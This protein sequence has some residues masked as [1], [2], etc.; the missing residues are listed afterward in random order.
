VQW[1]PLLRKFAN[2]LG[3]FNAKGGA[4]CETNEFVLSRVHTVVGALLLVAAVLAAVVAS[5]PSAAAAQSWT[6]ASPDGSISITV[7]LDS[8]LTY[9]VQ[10]QTGSGSIPV[11]AD[12]KLGLQRTD[13]LF[14]TGLT[15][16]NASP[17]VT[18]DEAYVRPHGKTSPLRNHGVQQVLEFANPQGHRLELVMRA[19]NDGVAFR[20]R[21]PE[22]DSRTFIITEELTTFNLAAEGRALLQQ[23]A[24]ESFHHL[25]TIASPHPED[26][27]GYAVPGLFESGPNWV[28][29]AES[30][31]DHSYF[32]GQLKK[33]AGLLEYGIQVPDSHYGLRDPSWT[34]P[35]EMPWR[36]IIIGSEVGDVIESNLVSH[37]AAPSR[38]AD[39][40]WIVPGRV[41]W[42]WWA[43]PSQ[44]GVWVGDA[45]GLRAYIDFAA[46]MG[47]EYS[48][49]DADWD[50]E[51]S[52]AEMRALIDYADA[53]GVGVF[54][55]YNSAGPHNDAE[56]SPR[57]KLWENTIR[58]AEFA[59]L[60]AWG[61]KGIKVDFF[62]SDKQEMIQVYLG[63]LED[64][65]AQEILVVFHASTP[66]RGWFRTWPNMLST[67]AVRGGEYYKF[68]S[69]F[70]EP[71][72][73]HHVE[74]AFTRAVV[75]PMDYTPVMFSDNVYAHTTTNAHELALSVVYESGFVALADSID[76]YQSQPQDVQAFL[77]ELPVSWDEI[78]FLEGDPI[79]H[80]V[81]ARRDGDDWYIAGINGTD[82]SIPVNI[83]LTQFGYGGDRGSL[84]ADGVTSRTF[85]SS[86]ITG[87]QLSVTMSP[88]GGFVATLPEPGG[89]GVPGDRVGLFDPRSGRWHLRAA[90]NDVRRFFFGVPGDEPLFG[91]WNCD[92]V[93]TVGMYRPS[94]GFVYLR[95]SN[96]FGTADRVF[97]FG[98]PGDMP[99]VGDWD[100][101]GC[102]T[103]AVYRNGEVLVANR[104]GTVVAEFSFFF[105]LPGDRPFAG[106]FDGDG[107][108]TVAVH[109]EAT[110]LVYLR[111]DLQTGPA[112]LEFFYGTAADRIVAGDWDNDGDQTVGVFRPSATRF[113]LSNANRTAPADIEFIF[114]QSDW[115]PV[116]G[117]D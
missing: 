20:Y 114:G 41:S 4:R 17:K 106:D 102:D 6:V 43:L 58:E 23:R 110:G 81:V 113:F 60:A 33:V 51:Y 89:T 68:D 49:I 79:S 65:A 26:G 95:N 36:V 85:A 13:T 112:Q 2:L 34:L 3:L 111:N 52:D 48:L 71:A 10:R 30:D 39:T 78:R 69:D 90:Q 32:A 56:F 74:V 38:I 1:R 55:W 31:L 70:P 19:Y 93:D 91:D 83:D 66:P 80:F 75:G 5:A 109:R 101:D 72:P 18:I 53:R 42:H 21:F 88:R 46:E 59:K 100:G 98:G 87:S 107:T 40:S 57:D 8:A 28:M 24:A 14:S 16:V 37:L 92:G 15:L 45:A 76:S 47:W 97:F 86:R 82:S 12:S 9:R 35:W 44:G 54:L 7:E 50:D 11:I 94:N 29:L 62:E 73:L 117:A 116:A 115:L 25:T 22:S 103:L 96:D 105:G 108:T 77:A 67:E 63:I 84:I 27:G 64:A 104:L 99:L 61:V